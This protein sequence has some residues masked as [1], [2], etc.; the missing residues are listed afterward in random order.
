M[1]SVEE[2]QQDIFI[3]EYFGWSE[4]AWEQL[5]NPRVAIE[6]KQFCRDTDAYLCMWIPNCRDMNVLHNYEKQLT[7]NQ[8]IARTR[9]LF[10]IC[11]RDYGNEEIGPCDI[12]SNIEITSMLL[13]CTPEQR[14]EALF[15]VV[16]ES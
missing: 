1:E 2:K 15:C 11:D 10:H 8:K 7:P 5:V 14:K 3:A 4:I 12:M 6:E 9:A 13:D 16:S